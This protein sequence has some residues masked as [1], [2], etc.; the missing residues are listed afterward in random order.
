MTSLERVKVN[1]R[2]A[3]PLTLDM[4]P[5]LEGR[6]WEGND[7]SDESQVEAL[8]G[9]INAPGSLRSQQ[10][11]IREAW[12]EAESEAR[13]V[14][15]GSPHRLVSTPELLMGSSFGDAGVA[16]SGSVSR[17]NPSAEGLSLE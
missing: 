7:N 6:A 4:S 13:Q 9:D 3:Y 15:L 8:A 11:W 12:A 10:T 1:D 14:L 2:F 5:F 16:I 17:S